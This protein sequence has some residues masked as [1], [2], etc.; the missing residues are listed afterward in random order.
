MKRFVLTTAVLVSIGCAGSLSAG[1]SGTE[2]V[3]FLNS[4]ESPPN[5]PFSEAVRVGN[6][7]YLSGRIGIV[8]GTMGLAPGGIR[9]ETRQTMENIERSLGAHGYSMDDIVKCTVMLADISEWAAFNEVYKSF[10][11][12][13]YPARSAFGANGLAL[14]AR[15]EVECIA[16]A[17]GQ[18]NKRR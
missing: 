16:A 9:E 6:T 17:G 1:E 10:F 7:L 13:P 14:G 12:K 2:S 5:L 11:K 3:E 4:G 15:V 18:G 8:P